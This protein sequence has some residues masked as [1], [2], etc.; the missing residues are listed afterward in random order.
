MDDAPEEQLNA[1]VYSELRRRLITGR[2]RPGHKMSTRTLA[3]ELGVSQTPVRDALSR[4]AAEGAVAI[5]FK[6]RILVPHMTQAR[7]DDILRCRLLL[8]PEAAA[9]ATPFLSREHLEKLKDA[10]RRLDDAVARGDADAYINANHAFHFTFYA[11]QP[12]ATM[13]Q[14]IETLWL[15]YGPFMRHAYDKVASAELKD[16][17]QAAIRAAAERDADGVKAAIAQDI[18]DGMKL[19]AASGLTA[20]PAA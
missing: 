12:G 5:R 18:S 13:L 3:A 15:Q 4:L 2:V 11:V 1:S 9:R 7:M 10:D 16:S 6:R 19:I 17:H 20:A 14:L 8:E